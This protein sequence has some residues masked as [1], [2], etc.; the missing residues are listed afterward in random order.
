MSNSSF[1]VD[2]IASGGSGTVTSIATTAPIEG[3]TITTSGTL[4]LA[5]ASVTP[6]NY[7]SANITVDAHGLIQSASNGTGSGTAFQTVNVQVFTSSGTYTPSAFMQYCIIECVGGG[8]G[9]GG[10]ASAAGSTLSAGAGGG[11]GAYARKAVS[12]ATI[13]ASQA[14]TIGNGG[15]GGASGF[16]NGNNG[17]STSVGTICVADGG[18]GGEG[19]T[20]GSYSVAGKGGST[21]TGD[22]ILVG[23]AGASCY[24][25]PSSGTS[26]GALGYGGVSGGQFG[27]V[28]IFLNVGTPQTGPD[29]I[30]YGAGG[31]G[32][33]SFSGNGAAAGGGGTAG[34]VIITEYI[35]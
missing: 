21:G 15:T 6:G 12:A 22:I 25:Q 14:V 1:T 17:G 31:G 29:G 28:G 35:S 26:F 27:S 32:G 33:I 30:G 18:S 23:S 4:S 16:N 24:A 7:T 13:G 2:G 19:N 20:G 3:G 34:I 11:G 8:G 5:N 10:T 9:G